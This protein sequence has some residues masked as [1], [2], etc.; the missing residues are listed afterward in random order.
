MKYLSLDL[1]TT[2]LNGGL[3]ILEI[4]AVAEDSEVKNMH[5][6]ALPYFHCYVLHEQ[7]F[8]EAMALA[9]NA[10]I[11]RKIAAHEFKYGKT[12]ALDSG[13]GQESFIHIQALKF[14][15][16]EWLCNV[17]GQNEVITLTGKNVGAFDLPFLRNIPGWETGR[18]HHRVLDPGTLY[19]DWK[20]DK[21]M[22]SMAQC[23]ERAG[24]TDVGGLHEALFDARMVIELLRHKIQFQ[25]QM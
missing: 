4:A 14:H 18:F 9:M 20:I 13:K 11:L 21:K 17:Y 10:S 19:V 1:E 8:G 6:D 23:A 25:P 22:P 12:S 3:Q 16:G 2:G 24:L 15:F 7:Y 5:V